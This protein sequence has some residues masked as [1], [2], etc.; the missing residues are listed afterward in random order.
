MATEKGK[1]P[2]Q[3]EQRKKSQERRYFSKKS[4]GEARQ[5]IPTLKYGRSNNFFVFQQA[6]YN[7]AL[8]DYGDLAKLIKLNKYCEITLEML[9]EAELTA[10]IKEEVI[11]FRKQAVIE[12]SQLKARM[13]MDRPMLYGLILSHMSMESKD[14]VT[15]DP[16]Y[17]TWQTAT[18][19]EKLWQAIMRTHRVDCVSHV[20]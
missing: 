4:N 7:Q 17:Q 14:E 3:D 13:K 18:D 10:L 15:Q 6:L 8:K 11:L 16:D 1:E 5:G 20:S 19:P 2:D 9:T 12:Y